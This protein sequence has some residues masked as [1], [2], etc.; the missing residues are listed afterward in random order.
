[1]RCSSNASRRGRARVAWDRA[2][3]PRGRELLF[4]MPA[5]R[6]RYSRVPAIPLFVTRR[7]HCDHDA[8]KSL[9]ENLLR[10][11]RHADAADPRQ[12]ECWRLQVET[13]HEAQDVD[14]DPFVERERGACD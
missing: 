12:E 8:T 4:L 14:L 13:D 2:A 10:L 11:P 7:R 3:A 1:M 5:K 9:R 6:E